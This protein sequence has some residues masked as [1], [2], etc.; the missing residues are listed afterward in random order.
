MQEQELNPDQDVVTIWGDLLH[1]SDLFDIL[2]KYVRHLQLGKK[3]TSLAYSYKFEEQF[4]HRYLEIFS[5]HFC[6]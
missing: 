6:E 4:D 2:R 1:D 5:L 3:P